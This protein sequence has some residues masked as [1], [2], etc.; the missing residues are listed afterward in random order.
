MKD[1]HKKRKAAMAAGCGEYTELK[2]EKEFFSEAKKHSRMACVF[3][4][5]GMDGT[6]V[7]FLLLISVLADQAH[8]FLDQ[9]DPVRGN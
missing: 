7:R 4:R 9:A 6:V 3:V 8:D 2:D 5:E 1:D